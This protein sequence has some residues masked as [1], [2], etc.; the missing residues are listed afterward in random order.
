MSTKLQLALAEAL[1]EAGMPEKARE[2]LETADPW[3]LKLLGDR[4]TEAAKARFDVAR[5]VKLVMD[6]PANGGPGVAQDYEVRKHWHPFK[7]EVEV[8]RVY[9]KD[10]KRTGLMYEDR[11]VLLK[12][13]VAVYT[14][15]NIVY[16]DAETSPWPKDTL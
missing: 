6:D 15:R 16:N 13:L 10:G 9:G 12:S 1:E 8:Y 4:A 5:R 2:A 11:D 3:L 14:V 7:P